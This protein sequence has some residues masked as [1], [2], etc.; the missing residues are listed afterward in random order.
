MSSRKKSHK[1]EIRVADQYIRKKLHEDAVKAIDDYINEGKPFILYLRKYD[2]IFHHGKNEIDRYL[3]DNYISNNLPKGINLISV[4]DRNEITNIKGT[5]FYRNVPS[6]NLSHN[7]WEDVVDELI[8]EADIIICECPLLTPGVKYELT[9]CLKHK[10]YNQTVLILPPPNEIFK[11]IDDDKL[12]QNFP[13]CFWYDEFSTINLIDSFVIRDL[14]ERTKEI[15]QLSKEERL[16]LLPAARR[17][18]RYPITYKGVVV[19]YTTRADLIDIGPIAQPEE[20]VLWYYKFWSYFRANS[21][22]GILLTSGQVKIEDIAY[23]MTNCYLKMANLMLRYRK[24]NGIFVIQG[25][26]EFA[27]R[28][29][30]SAQNFALNYPTAYL[31]LESAKKLVADIHLLQTTI[32]NNREKFVFK[33]LVKP[34]VTKR[35]SLKEL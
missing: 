5:I 4:Q 18:L 6:F 27:R 31:Y 24:E 3:T 35:R 14:L 19:G 17:L 23:E 33:P 25:D 12:I 30:L 15:A 16:Q 34:L 32:S 13:R 29:A 20:D 10:K 8:M 9:S 2:I 28:C 11:T 22:Q 1:K 26:I 7:E 21:V